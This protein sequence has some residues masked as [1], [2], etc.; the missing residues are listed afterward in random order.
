M[1]ILLKV[2][3]ILVVLVLA[4][5]V[6]VVIS[7]VLLAAVIS[8]VLLGVLLLQFVGVLKK[9]PVSYNLR[10][11]I[12]RWRT[13]A[14]TAVAFSLV[15]A[16]LTVMLAFIQGMYRLTE[17][18]GVP[19]N[20]FVLADGATD[21]QFSNLGFG[22]IKEIQVNPDV[23]RDDDNQPLAS[24]EVYVVVNQPIE[25]R[26]CPK[27][28]QIAPVDRL[29]QRLLEHGDPPCPGSGK[30]VA[31][32]EADTWQ[33]R[34]WRSIS[35]LWGGSTTKGPRGRRFIQVRGIEDP[36]KSGKVHHLTL[37]PGGEWFSSAGVQALEGSST[38]EQLI[39]AVIG[40][41]LARE[42]GPD[43]GKRSLDVGD[44]FD[45]GSRKWVVVGILQSSGSTF[46]SEVWG[47]FSLMG[48]LFGKASYTTCVLRA[49]SPGDAD[50]LADDLSKNYKKQAVSA[51][52]EPAYYSKLNTTNAQFLYSTRIVI[53]I[54]AIGS[55]FGVM[56][57]M[58]AAIAQRTKDI[59]VMRILGYSRLQVLTSFFM[60][61]L[62]LALL[63]GVVGCALGLL[64][65]G[66]SATSILSSGMGGGKSVVLKLIVD[67]QILGLGMV[68][69]L[70]MG[71]IGGLLPALSAV[72]LKALDAV[73]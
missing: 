40:E 19:S 12:V 66:Y 56:N 27:C 24:W 17:N 20:V 8:I 67:W 6:L 65:N 70:F 71:C 68:F 10:N 51:Q 29:G 14:L 36:V 18:S 25:V 22:D 41:G 46:D 59:G 64:C 7:A 54:M 72:R 21:E 28:G 38:G 42:L 39:Q 57:T 43:Q 23:V 63:G 55:C 30:D 11:L 34:S 35:W 4:L 1:S 44:I 60:E 33:A 9:V 5:A 61:S 73:R 52:T 32:L 53:F 3:I 26:K 37:R 69:S 48:E 31:E 45:L 47:K 2:L 50:R 58:F 62:V 15:V 13:T 16:L 49:A